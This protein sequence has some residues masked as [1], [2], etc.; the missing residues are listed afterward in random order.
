MLFKNLRIYALPNKLNETAE[1][2]DEALAKHCFK[3]CGIREYQ[4]FGWVTPSG[5]E[6][7]VL[8]DTGSG[9]FLV[10]ANLEEKVLPASV[11][12]DAVNKAAELLDHK[13]GKKERAGMREEIIFDLLAKAFTRSAKIHAMLDLRAGY[14]FVDSA[15]ANRAESLI[16]LLR[17]SLGSLPTVPLRTNRKPVTVMSAWLEGTPPTSI[18]IGAECELLDPSE[19]GGVAK[20][21][22]Q[23]LY[24]DEVQSNLDSGKQVVK[25]AL[26]WGE[27]LSFVL[28][29]SLV[30]KRLKFI[31]LDTEEPSPAADFAILS[32]QLRAL[33][34]RLLS[35]FGGLYEE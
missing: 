13:P 19:G 24:T 22:R 23:D 11:V 9:C 15:S 10:C 18:E 26:T 7:L 14:M 33:L 16:G 17:A 5:D 1:S 34:L 2:L 27:H 6:S 31:G 30:I 8:K 12:N 21:K 3:P 28:D 20:F 35:V 29:D 32:A 4:S 25:L